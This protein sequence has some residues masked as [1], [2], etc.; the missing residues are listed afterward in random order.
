MLAKLTCDSLAFGRWRALDRGPI[1][2]EYLFLMCMCFNERCTIAGRSVHDGGGEIYVCPM[3][4]AACRKSKM[5][6][7]L[8]ALNGAVVA[9]T[10]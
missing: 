9:S 5:P 4:D 8:S 1:G 7:S 10:G 6:A 2:S 3:N